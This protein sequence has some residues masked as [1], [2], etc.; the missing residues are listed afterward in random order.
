M[1]Y[2]F[3]IIVNAATLCETYYVSRLL[4]Y[5]TS[6]MTLNTLIGILLHRKAE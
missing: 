4:D 2:E 3:V 5:P 6:C 1:N